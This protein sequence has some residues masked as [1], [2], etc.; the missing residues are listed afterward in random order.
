[1][2]KGHK[3][4]V[5]ISTSYFPIMW[6]APEPVTLTVHAGKS[7][8][9]IPVRKQIANEAPLGWKQAEA[10][11][12]ARL[13]QL[14]KPWN[15]R[16]TKIDAKTGEARIEIVDDFGAFEIAPHGLITHGVGRETYSI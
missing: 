7:L 11:A 1:I 8:V 10:A 15:K 2:P 14:K 13:K 9:H 4:R 5:S 6:P 3:L 12:P 16:D